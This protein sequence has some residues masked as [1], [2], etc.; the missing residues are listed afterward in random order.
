MGT[1]DRQFPRRA[2]LDGPGHHPFKVTTR[3]RI[4]CATP[5]K[6][7]PR[8]VAAGMSAWAH[9]P[10]AGGSIPLPATSL[11]PCVTS[12]RL[13][14]GRKDRAAPELVTGL[15]HQGRC[16][17]GSRGSPAKGE[18]ARAGAR[19]RI[20][21]DPP[22]AYNRAQH[23]CKT[24]LIDFGGVAQLVERLLC[25]QRVAGSIPVSSTISSRGPLAQW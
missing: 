16:P 13:E 2:R 17:R 15:V 14:T 6:Q 1:T 22:H 5:E 25:K 9:I 18:S 10:S 12:A 23:V 24:R 11:R 3:V 4:P 20:A 19:V 8:G 7:H 21:H